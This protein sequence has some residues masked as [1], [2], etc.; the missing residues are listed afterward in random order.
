MG[1]GGT[2]RNMYVEEGCRPLVGVTRKSLES[3]R[4]VWHLTC[5]EA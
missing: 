1:D 3:E 5:G 2:L 4:G